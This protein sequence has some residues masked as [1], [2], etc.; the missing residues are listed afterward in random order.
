LAQRQDLNVS[1]VEPASA[2][3]VN[4]IRH[5]PGVI[6]CEPFRSVSVRLRHD[7]R[8]RLVAIMGLPTDPILNRLLDERGQALSLPEEGLVLSAKLGQILGAE[9]GDVLTVEVLEGK[10]PTFRVA[11][12]GLVN[13]FMGTS[14]YM[15]LSVLNRSLREGSS[16]SGVYVTADARYHDALYRTLKNTPRVAG[17]T[18]KRAAL[19]NFQDIVAQNLLIQRIFNIGFACIIAFGVVYNNARISL[20]ERSRELATLRVI[21]FTRTEISVILLG[22]IGVLTLLAIPLGLAAGYGLSALTL[23]GLDTEMFRVPLVINLSTFG[24]AA[25]VVVVATILSAL[26]VRRNLDHLDLVAVLKSKE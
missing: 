14:A 21:G 5:L 7:Q 6:H 17:V 3:A 8:E 20:S 10:R 23:M 13:D 2:R 15:Q 24:F 1:F 25:S 26:V 11:V 19:Q 9:A 18:I 12:A 4:T 22:E 16:V